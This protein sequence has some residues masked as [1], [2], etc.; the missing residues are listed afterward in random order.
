[1]CPCSVR[2][3]HPCE[4]LSRIIRDYRRNIFSSLFSGS[5][6]SRCF[7]FRH[8]SVHGFLRRSSGSGVYWRNKRAGIF[9][10]V[11][12]QKIHRCSKRS[13]V[14]RDFAHVIRRSRRAQSNNCSDLARAR[15]HF[16][17]WLTLRGVVF[18]FESGLRHCR[19]GTQRFELGRIHRFWHGWPW[20]ASTCMF[21]WRWF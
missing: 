6:I 14:R 8:S 18:K 21:F 19:A 5:L 10:G 16:A 9:L 4:A 11:S 12:S 7:L 3:L 2:R 20:G 13:T 17:A 1:M 15:V